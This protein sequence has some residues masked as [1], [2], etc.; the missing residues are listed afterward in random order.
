[1]PAYAYGSRIV[2][3]IL[4]RLMTS[5]VPHPTPVSCHVRH[6]I[7]RERGGHQLGCHQGTV[8]HTLTGAMYSSSSS[9]P[10][11]KTGVTSGGCHDDSDGQALMQSRTSPVP[12]PSAGDTY[13]YHNMNT[14]THK[15]HTPLSHC[16][17]AIPGTIFSTASLTSLQVQPAC[18][19]WA[20]CLTCS[21][22]QYCFH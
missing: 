21:V 18:P 16:D 11:V 5:P 7:G 17:F 9:S 1:M 22:V 4:Q 8:E 10:N 2:A 6:S 19:P 15:Q 12:C 20:N 14:T 3:A 13:G